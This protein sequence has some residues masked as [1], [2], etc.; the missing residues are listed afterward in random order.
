MEKL[1]KG[2]PFIVLFLW[3]NKCVSSNHGKKDN[4][5]SISCSIVS[6]VRPANATCDRRERNNVRSTNA[7]VVKNETHTTNT[8]TT[9]TRVFSIII[10]YLLIMPMRS[11][12][13]YFFSQNYLSVTHT[14]RSQDA[15]KKT[16]ITIQNIMGNPLLIQTRSKRYNYGTLLYAFSSTLSCIP[17]VPQVKS[18]QFTVTD[19]LISFHE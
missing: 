19:Q 2:G 1:L 16:L 9:S 10:V 5:R 7:T 13:L 18:T 17:L 14:H 12:M 15:K 8:H 3:Q 11:F 6:V 4:V